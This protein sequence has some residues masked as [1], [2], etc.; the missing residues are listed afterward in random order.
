MSTENVP[1]DH[2]EHLF[3][4]LADTITD[5]G[6]YEHYHITL[7]LDNRPGERDDYMIYLE[8]RKDDFE[9]STWYRTGSSLS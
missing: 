9:G 4:P 6:G 3:E 1:A 5:Q 8:V 7:D 2:V